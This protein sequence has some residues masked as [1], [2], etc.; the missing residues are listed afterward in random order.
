MINKRNNLILGTIGLVLL[1]SLRPAFALNCTS[2]FGTAVG[3]TA[4]GHIAKAYFY[5]AG[6]SGGKYNLT[7]SIVFGTGNPESIVGECK[8]RHLSF[9]RSKQ[10]Q[11]VQK[12]SGMLKTHGNASDDGAIAGTFSHSKIVSVGSPPEYPWCGKFVTLPR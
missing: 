6:Y 10:N 1:V 2:I 4:N 5:N 3:I 11:W 7:G 8:G 12:Y 9:I